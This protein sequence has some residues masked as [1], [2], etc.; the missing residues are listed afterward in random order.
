MQCYQRSASGQE[1]GCEKTEYNVSRYVQPG[2]HHVFSVRKQELQIMISLLLVA[3]KMRHTLLYASVLFLFA[4]PAIAKENSPT[5]PE[6]AT[7]EKGNTAQPDFFADSTPLPA[8]KAP[9][10]RSYFTVGLGSR[11]VLADTQ[12]MSDTRQ[13][14]S[15][16][17]LRPNEAIYKGSGV[18]LAEHSSAYTFEPTLR[19]EW[20]I[21]AER[22][23]WLSILWSLEGGYSPARE[24]LSAAGS[25]RYQNAQAANVALTDLT[26][27]GSLS[28]TEQRFNLTPM[29]GLGAEYTNGWLQGLQE[30]HLLA[31]LSVGAMFAS[32]QRHYVLSLAPQYVSAVNDTYV[33]QSEITQSHT[34]SVLP[35]AR[36]ELGA[37]AR[38]SSRLHIALLFSVTAVYGNIGWESQGY[39]AE[40]AG[41]SADKNIYQKV[42]SG[43]ADQAYLGLAPAV[44]LALS[45]EL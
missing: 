36:A 22:Y 10:R 23:S 44:F 31:R 16:N 25:F 14:A 28:V 45:T 20:E 37:R 26:Y 11:M 6:P 40:R 27:S 43:I 4:L 1:Y 38:L 33:I 8:Q 32:G 21:P 29:F 30:T 34:M 39:F 12:G 13:F 42:V 9:K 3:L 35:A 15:D 19:A 18:T 24:I 7:D 41:L 5:A 2:N 17:I